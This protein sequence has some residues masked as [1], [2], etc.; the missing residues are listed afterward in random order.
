MA[1]AAPPPPQYNHFLSTQVCRR[2][3]T[4]PNRWCKGLGNWRGSTSLFVFRRSPSRRPG[5][6]PPALRYAL[7][8]E[9]AGHLLR[10]CEQP[11]DRPRPH[12]CP[13]QLSAPQVFVEFL[14]SLTARPLANV[15]KSHHPVEFFAS[16]LPRLTERYAVFY[17]YRD[18]VEMLLSFWRF[19]HRWDWMGPKVVDPLTFA[20][21]KP[22][23]FPGLRRHRA[24]AGDLQERRR[25]TRRHD[26]L[27]HGAGA[28]Q[29]LLGA[30][31]VRAH[32][33]NGNHGL[34]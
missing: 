21:S 1:F 28:R 27:Q 19:V 16:E 31:T 8:A 4:D 18:L 12:H 33:T 23:A 3:R 14:L 17:I 20:R 10:L 26:R 7:P 24:W 15:L 32:A 13:G 11:V 22:S 25:G 34:A 5:G 2:S 30:P 6:Q 29:H 9:R